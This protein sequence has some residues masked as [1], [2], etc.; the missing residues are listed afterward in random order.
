MEGGKNGKERR[1]FLTLSFFFFL[2][3]KNWFCFFGSTKI[4]TSGSKNQMGGWS[5]LE[6]SVFLCGERALVNRGAS[7]FTFSVKF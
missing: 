1:P 3:R 2:I 4:T 5:V 6:L 7:V